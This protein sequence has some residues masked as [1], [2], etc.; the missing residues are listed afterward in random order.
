MLIK[1]IMIP[2]EEVEKTRPT[3]R[4][5]QA[6]LKMARNNIGGLPVT[7]DLNRVIGF[8]TLR[9]ISI[10]SVPAYFRVEEI[11]S[12]NL[13]CKKTDSKVEEAINVMLETG[14][15]RIPIVNEKKE[16]QGLIT[17]TSILE[18]ARNLV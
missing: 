8:I 4:I 16:L 18:L 6:K 2:E 9:D 5:V 15:Q 13:V 11:M 1:E 7:D 12:E 10:S 14:L 17:Q 3:E